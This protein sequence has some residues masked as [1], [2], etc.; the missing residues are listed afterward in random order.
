MDH[1]VC[2]H[3]GTWGAVQSKCWVDG[4]IESRQPATAE[5]PVPSSGVVVGPTRPQR[6]RIPST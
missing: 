2:A 3:L 6:G 5:A 4:M 1:G